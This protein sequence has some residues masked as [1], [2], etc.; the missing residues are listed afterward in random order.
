MRS[1]KCLVLVVLLGIVV[2]TGLTMSMSILGLTQCGRPKCTCFTQ[3][4]LVVCTP[5]LGP[6]YTEVSVCVSPSAD[7]QC[8]RLD[9]VLPTQRYSAVSHPFFALGNNCI[10][11]TGNR[12]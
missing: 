2:S 1:W 7:W 12:K 8:V 3:R 4:G 11:S 6:P 5:G 10:I 9:L